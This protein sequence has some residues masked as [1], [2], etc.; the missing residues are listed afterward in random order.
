MSKFPRAITTPMWSHGTWPCSRLCL[1]SSP[2][3]W[4]T[5]ANHGVHIGASQNV[6]LAARARPG[7]RG[8]AGNHRLRAQRCDQ[9]L[10]SRLLLELQSLAGSVEP[11]LR[12]QSGHDYLVH[13]GQGPRLPDWRRR[14]PAVLARS[15]PQLRAQR[16]R[17]SPQFRGES[18]L[19]TSLRQGQAL[20]KLPASRPR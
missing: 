2:F 5:S 12:Q 6:N 15:A 19:R 9:C 7:H 17:P 16:L 4:P 13:L 14:R 11:P 1:D 8:L 3:S 18:H 20:V 10:L